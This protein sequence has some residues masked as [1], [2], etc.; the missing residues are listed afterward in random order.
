MEKLGSID[1]CSD[2]LSVSQNKIEKSNKAYFKFGDEIA[3]ANMIWTK[4]LIL[5]SCDEET[6]EKINSKLLMADPLTVGGPLAFFYLVQAVLKTSDKTARL[7]V[8]KL[9]GLKLSSISGEDIDRLSLIIKGVAIRLKSV[10]KLPND[11]EEIVKGIFQTSTVFAFRNHFT[12]LDVT[13]NPIMNNYIS[14]LDAGMI[15]FIE[16]SEAGTYLPRTKTKSAFATG[17]D[18]KTFVQAKKKWEKAPVDRTAPNPGE[19]ITRI[20]K[21]GR[22]ET[23]CSHQRCG[24]WGNHDV[25][26]HNA[27]H[28]SFLESMEKRKERQARI[29]VTDSDSPPEE[30]TKSEETPKK[31]KQ[32]LRFSEHSSSRTNVSA[33]QLQRIGT[34]SNAANV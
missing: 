19:A 33:S 32:R 27:W 1:L 28:K 21:D 9:T 12:I 26:G 3:V 2:Y 20:N 14:I 17:S 8:T 13:K 23:F 11:M 22:T 6:Y 25:D 7:L 34:Y 5:N 15:L 24:R 30:T 31:E 29:A 10:G 4:D 18:A 16:L